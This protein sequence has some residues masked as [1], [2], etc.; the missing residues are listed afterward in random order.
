MWQNKWKK[1]KKYKRGAVIR[2]VASHK[3]KSMDKEEKLVYAAHA[4][5]LQRERS[6]VTGSYQRRKRPLEVAAEVKAEVTPKKARQS[7]KSRFFDHM[8]DDFKD[9]LHDEADTPQKTKNVLKRILTSCSQRVPG[10]RQLLARKGLTWQRNIGQ[11][12]RPAGI[13]KLSD[14]DLARKLEDHS[15]ETST[16]HLGLKR[17]IRTLEQSKRQTARALKISKSQLCSRTRLCKLGYA[18]AKVQRGKCDS[19][20]A[21]EGGYRKR[22]VTMMA[23][24]W[25]MMKAIVPS[26]WKQFEE[27]V[28]AAELDTRELPGVD[29]PEYM[30]KLLQYLESAEDRADCRP[31]DEESLAVLCAHEAAAIGEIQAR[32]PDIENMAWHN[33][34]RRTMSRLWQISWNAPSSKVCYGLW[35][36]MV[37]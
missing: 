7:Q 23:E 16:M 12:G 26:Y 9:F 32:L 18:A 24:L 2:K 20:A 1:Y 25:K 19:C 29:D 35:D 27:E 34:L 14:S 33:S 5:E 6:A 15:Q 3:W 28:A 4:G 22:L 13:R 37:P 10:S 11:R 31:E 30:K 17:P 21:W 8:A 36:H